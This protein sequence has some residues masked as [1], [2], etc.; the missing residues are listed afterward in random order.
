ALFHLHE[1][2]E[3]RHLDQPFQLT[4]GCSLHGRRTASR[5]FDIDI[6]VNPSWT[7]ASARSPWL[8][9]ASY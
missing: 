4:V 2:H 9:P 8:W 3:P 7:L 5:I 6:D 1:S